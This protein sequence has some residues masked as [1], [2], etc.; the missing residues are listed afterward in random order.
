MHAV[1]T[2]N[3]KSEKKMGR[4]KGRTQDHPLQMRVNQEFLA[5]IDDW[6]RQQADFPNRTE[7]IRRLVE[8]ALKR[9]K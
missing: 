3:T 8:S 6:R 5:K 1:N 4:P 2:K 7:S 9:G